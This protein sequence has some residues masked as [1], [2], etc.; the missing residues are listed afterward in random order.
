MRKKILAWA[1]FLACLVFLSLAATPYS[2]TADRLLIT[3][4]LTLLL[5]LSV[6]VVRERWRNRRAPPNTEAPSNKDVGDDFLERCRRW[7]H[8]QG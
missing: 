6:L 7:Y 1:L 8:G 5:V 4:R 3:A 2:R